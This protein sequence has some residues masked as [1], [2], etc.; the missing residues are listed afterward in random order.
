MKRIGLFYF[1]IFVISVSF[2]ARLAY[3][4]LFTDRYILN[5]FNT[6][7]KK[8]VVYPKRGDILDRNGK[9]LV[10]NSY[11][12]E[13]QITPFLLEKGFDTIKFCQL[14]G[15]T[16][17]DFNNRMEE[18][19]S[20]KGYSKVATFPL[21]KGLNREDFTRFQEQMYKY[22]A[23]DVVQK[24]K[25]EYR[26]STAGNVLGY[27]QEVSPTYIKRDSS[28]YDPGDLA[29]MAGVEKSYENVL[30]GVKGVKY[31]KKDIRLRTIGSYENGEKDVQVQN[32]KTINLSIDYDLQHYAETLLKNKRGAVVAIEPSTG[33]ILALASSP[34][35]DPHRYNIP[36]E[37]SRMMLDS[38]NK[39]MY[40]RSL[41]A[42]YPPGSPFKI[43][44][45]LAAFQ[46]GVSD[47]AK[48]YTCHHGFYYGRAHMNCHCG[49]TNLKIKT[50]I[51]RSCNSYFSKTWV[52]ILKKD[53]ISIEN[54]IDEWADI[55]HSF[56]LGKFL[57][58]DMPVGSKGNIP[59]SA[60][61][62]RFLGKGKWNPFSIIS[63]GIGQGEILSTPIQMAN[64]M[65]AVA[66]QGYYYTPHIV[67]KIDGDPTKDTIYT[68]KR[69]TKVDP[70][71]FPNFLKGMEYVFSRAGTARAYYTKRFTQA[72]KTGTSQNPH[73]ADHSLFTII[74]PVENPKIV[75]A[76]VVE[77]GVWGA[78]WAAPIASLV[79][80]K[81]I[82][83]DIEEGKRKSLE[84]RMINGDLT[85]T[86]RS[87]EKERLKRLGWYVESKKDSIAIQQIL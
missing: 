52:D 16:V 87:V 48:V 14:I 22:P 18:I 29:G 32:G 8:E 82:F 17:A 81:Y 70:K 66:N 60:Y 51:E 39:I 38:I 36:G 25:R 77:N 2:I 76:V 9:L 69:Y 1:L 56:G 37:I 3:L 30:R 4:Q 35:I 21:I 6:S 80:E 11:D 15:I 54:S 49:R 65:A 71:Y 44:T 62:N 74:A 55:M 41:Q 46:M 73:G 24:P 26:V 43:M 45:G 78:R 57:G 40:D 64:A 5:A 20:I 86:Y 12:Y 58:T 28:Y 23:I 63:N 72:G 59:N 84:N 7:I 10:T 33:E 42:A 31:L 75:V 27:I 34:Y 19:K 83:G 50:A 53:S 79:A 68:T 13:L 85:P 47:S 67:K 61:Y